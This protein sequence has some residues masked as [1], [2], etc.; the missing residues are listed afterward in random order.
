MLQLPIVP[1]TDLHALSSVTTGDSPRHPS[2]PVCPHGAILQGAAGHGG[3]LEQTRGGGD[4]SGTAPPCCALSLQSTA[5][6]R[7]QGT[8]VPQ[9]RPWAAPTHPPLGHGS[10]PGMGCWGTPG[11]PGRLAQAPCPRRRGE[12]RGN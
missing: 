7:A 12:P 9:Q 2:H 6:S 3:C 11:L 5:G 8:G 1:H 10:V 4:P